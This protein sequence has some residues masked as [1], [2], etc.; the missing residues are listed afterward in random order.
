MCKVNPDN[1]HHIKEHRLIVRR[2]GKGDNKGYKAVII[3]FAVIR[4]EGLKGRSLQEALKLL[5]DL[6]ADKLK[7]YMKDYEDMSFS[8]IKGE[9]LRKEKDGARMAVKV[10]RTPKKA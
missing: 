5:F 6:T 4:I 3:E 8:H 1:A 2:C 9:E 7:E 10:P